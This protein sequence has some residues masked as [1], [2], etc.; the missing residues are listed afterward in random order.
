[1]RVFEQ[2]PSP[3]LCGIET[4]SALHHLVKQAVE[5]VKVRVFRLVTGQDLCHRRKRLVW[6]LPNGRAKQLFELARI[7]GAGEFGHHTG[8]VSIRHFRR[9]QKRLA[10]LGGQAVSPPIPKETADGFAFVVE[11][12]RSV[13][14]KVAQ[15]RCVARAQR[16]H[17]RP[18]ER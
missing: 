17:V 9:V 7:T 14:P 15:R 1:M 11:V 13:L 8:F 2:R 4:R 16:L 6:L 3:L 5:S 10:C 12:H 18:A